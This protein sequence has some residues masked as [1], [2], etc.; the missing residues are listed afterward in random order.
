M[1][2]GSSCGY[3]GEIPAALSEAGTSVAAPAVPDH[4]RASM[5]C[6]PARASCIADRKGASC[7][8]HAVSEQPLRPS[9][10][11]ARSDPLG[12]AGEN[13]IRARRC[14]VLRRSGRRL[15]CRT[16]LA[17]VRR[18]RVTD[19]LD[20]RTHGRRRLAR[21]L[22][23]LQGHS[24]TSVSDAG[25]LGSGLRGHGLERCQR[26]LTRTSREPRLSRASPR[27]TTPANCRHR[28]PKP[29]KARSRF[30]LR[31]PLLSRRRIP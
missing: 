17:I 4:K 8:P 28:Q 6:R 12:V 29:T 20:G 3:G 13:R 30:P 9:G 22:G 31:S 5:P 10:G 24:A 7:R 11:I 27:T 16:G 14:A 19:E 26:S 25:A 15:T 21:R 23:G 2:G 1:R 18:P